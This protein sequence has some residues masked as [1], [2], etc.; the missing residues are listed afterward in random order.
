LG[1]HR[2][3]RRSIYRI[4]L[5]W[6]LVKGL[7]LGLAMAGIYCAYAVVLFVARGASPFERN[8]TTLFEALA[9]YL[10]SGAAGGLL[11]GALYP[12]RRSLAGQL[13][14]GV[15][16]AALA[17]LC[18]GVASEEPA[19]APRHVVEDALIGGVVFGVAGTLMV[20]RTQRIR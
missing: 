17:F 2:R 8:G 19:G 20:R 18:I 11:Y 14:I 10:A 7:E 5:K 12:L 4:G 1:E 9:A 3:G 16:I 13:L 6:E 15:A